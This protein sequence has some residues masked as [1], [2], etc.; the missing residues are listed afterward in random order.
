MLESA[1]FARWTGNLAAA[2]C[3]W[4]VMVG[5][6][7]GELDLLGKQCPCTEGWVC[8]EAHNSCIPAD[9]TGVGGMAGSGGVGADGGMG[10]SGNVGA[11]AVTVSNLGI[12]WTTPN[13][14]R[15]SWDMEGTPD[16]LVGLEV[17]TGTSEQDVQDR[18][19][20]ARV[21]AAADNP[22]LGRY[23]LPATGGD[24][25]VVATTTD[26]HQPSTLYHCQL[27][28][29]DTAG[30]RSVSA[31]A[32]GRTTDPPTSTI[33]IFADTD[34]PG[35][36]LPGGIVRSDRN[37]YAGTHHYDF[38]QTCSGN[39][40][41]CYEMLRRMEMGTDLSGISQGALS[42]T[43][44]VEFALATEGPTP[45]YWTE[46]RLRTGTDADNQQWKY[47]GWSVRA[48][49]AYRLHQVPLRALTW[50]GAPMSKTEL[51]RGLHQ[52]GVGGSWKDT[53]HVAFDEIRIHW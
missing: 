5:C 6:S 24:E 27:T 19:G 10:G 40:T 31:L 47:D 1:V 36:S 37:P 17:V 2:L 13:S 21:W 52:F 34:P 53:G 23:F 50:E 33:V 28:A 20:S 22:E 30:R 3:A 7:V 35:Y 44:Y 38:V 48:D 8:D 9:G 45:S 39:E 29:I 49:G 25:P 14:M 16:Q 32:S 4:F 51:D 26:E 12:V 46:I 15:W 43:A 18:T 11:A 42:T 41:I